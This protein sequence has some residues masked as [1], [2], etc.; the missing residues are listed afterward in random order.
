M[1]LDHETKL[2][3]KEIV[4]EAVGSIST[5]CVARDKRLR[6]VEKKVFNGYGTSIK[7]LYL[8]YTILIG[9]A[10]KAVFF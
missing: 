5:V 4:E 6:E 8:A 3:V 9:L 2:Y 7:I 1:A 10:I